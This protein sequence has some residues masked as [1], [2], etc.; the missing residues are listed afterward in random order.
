M[1]INITK[2]QNLILRKALQSRFRDFMFNYGDE[3]AHSDH[4][5]KHSESSYE[6]YYD[7]TDSSLGRGFDEE[8]GYKYMGGKGI[9]KNSL[10]DDQPTYDVYEEHSESMR[11]GRD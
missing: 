11:G 4:N 7:H 3:D 5:D 9:K 2:I 6:D 8:K 10:Y 1:K